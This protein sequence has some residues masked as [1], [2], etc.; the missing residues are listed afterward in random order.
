MWRW[1]RRA[2]ERKSGRFFAAKG[3]TREDLKRAVDVIAS[4]PARWI[5]T[6]AT[7]EYGLAP[8]QR[9]PPRAAVR[10]F[11]AFC[12]PLLTYLFTGSL[13]ACVLGTGATFFAVGAVKSR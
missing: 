2:S 5:K 7:E 3:F 10:T 1:S 4:D 12:A 8:A 13:T 9:S 6:M 11:M